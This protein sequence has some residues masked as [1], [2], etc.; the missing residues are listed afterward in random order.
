MTIN[1]SIINPENDVLMSEVQAKR[2]RMEWKRA[3]VEYLIYR[4]GIV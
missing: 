2:M 4:I 3:R 1:L